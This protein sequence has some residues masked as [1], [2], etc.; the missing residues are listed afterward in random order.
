[1]LDA[2]GGGCKPG[3]GILLWENHG[4]DNQ[5]WK[6]EENGF[7][8]LKKY[9]ELCLDVAGGVGHG[10]NL[11]LWNKHGGDNQKFCLRKGDTIMAQEYRSL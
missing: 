8:S 5:I 10:H 11:V 9:P 2:A 1:M 6:L 3:D 4:G 7:I